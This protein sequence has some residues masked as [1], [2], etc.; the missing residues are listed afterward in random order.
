[1]LNGA[2][3]ALVKHKWS[4]GGGRSLQGS[5]VF[6]LLKA[7]LS[8]LLHLHISIKL[9]NFVPFNEIMSSFF[10]SLLAINI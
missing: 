9:I 7:L 4:Y 5:V 10:L 1:M 6:F 8:L 2:P 3:G